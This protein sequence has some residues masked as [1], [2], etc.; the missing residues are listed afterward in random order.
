MCR[1]PVE[2]KRRVV[3]H[4]IC[5]ACDSKKRRQAHARDPRPRLIQ[6]AAQRAKRFGVPFKLGIQD[7]VVPT[8]CPVLGIPLAVGVGS[9]AENSPS[10]DRIV[11]ARGYVPSNVRVISHRANRIR[12]NASVE[13]L[14]AVIAYAK[15]L[16]Q[17]SS[18]AVHLFTIH[19]IRQPRTY[20]G[21]L[22]RRRHGTV[23]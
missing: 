20:R 15:S 1:K 22:Y 18:P 10:L 14:E 2:R 19:R 13:E 9:A 3:Q 7:I 21:A 17:S 12:G 5:A 11:P 23:R 4:R 6:Q 16:I 8:H